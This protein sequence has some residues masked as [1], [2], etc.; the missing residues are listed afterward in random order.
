VE[1]PINNNLCASLEGDDAKPNDM[2]SCE[3]KKLD[4]K[5][6]R[7]IRQWLDDFIFH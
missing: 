2:L 7:F 5:D 3:L 6:V 1:D 4:H